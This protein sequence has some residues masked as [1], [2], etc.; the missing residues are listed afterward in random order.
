MLALMP[1]RGL[2]E[3]TQL[4]LERGLVECLFVERDLCVLELEDQL[5]DAC[6]L[7]LRCGSCVAD[8]EQTAK[9]GCC[10]CRS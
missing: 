6:V 5:Q 3:V 7:R 2:G 1:K 8:A 4:P 9:Q 10:C